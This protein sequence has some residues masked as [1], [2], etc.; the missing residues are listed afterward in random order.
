LSLSYAG[1]NNRLA[2]ELNYAVDIYVDDWN[3]VIQQV[4]SAIGKK[5]KAIL[6]SDPPSREEKSQ[7]IQVEPVYNEVVSEIRAI[8]NAWR[9]PGA[10]YRYR[11]PYDQRDAKKILD[12]VGDLM[13]TLAEHLP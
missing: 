7:W 3:E 11:R 6:S 12:K 9:N 8:K 10:H 2:A 13:R 5:K 1:L 4:E